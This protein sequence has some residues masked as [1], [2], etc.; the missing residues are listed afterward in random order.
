[1]NA[2]FTTE[3]AL[4]MPAVIFTI[5]MSVY[6]TAHVYNT[7][8][9]SASAGEQAVSGHEQADPPLFASGE[10]ATERTDTASGRTVKSTSGTFHFD[11]NLLW[12]IQVK[13]YFRKCHP[14]KLI[15]NRRHLKN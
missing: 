1:M 6:L 3:A 13:Q 2:S 4:L 9:L 11:G 7:A 10:I 8:C 14:V 15:R 12:D 5:L